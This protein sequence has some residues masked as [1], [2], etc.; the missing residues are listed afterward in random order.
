[1]FLKEDGVNIDWLRKFCLSLP[2]TTEDIKW[3]KDLCFC[4][5]EKMFCVT[6]I[7]QPEFG[8]SFKVSDEEFAE[9]T[10]RGGI[11]P[12]PYLARAK[13]VR[14]GDPDALSTDEWKRFVEGSYKLISSKLPKKVRDSL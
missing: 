4:V 2:G 13:W 1:M 9:L 5:G 6:G 3:E 11:E 10:E 14:V 12:A 7:D 8:A